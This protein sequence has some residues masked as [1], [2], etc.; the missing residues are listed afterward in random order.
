VLGEFVDSAVMTRSS[1]AEKR[2]SP[3]RLLLLAGALA[4]LF[5]MHGLGDHGT[6]H[7]PGPV[8]VGSH[9]VGAAMPAGTSDPSSGEQ[10]G[11]PS[12][13]AVGAMSESSAPARVLAPAESGSGLAGLCMAVL[14]GVL[15]ALAGLRTWGRRPAGVTLRLV[16]GLR[17]AAVA[18]ERDPPRLVQLSICRC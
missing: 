13:T 5:A 10:S 11:H 4:G 14:A 9:H 12:S 2:T 17:I 3:V 8:A 18:R 15:F 6:A 16:A 7:H 1:A